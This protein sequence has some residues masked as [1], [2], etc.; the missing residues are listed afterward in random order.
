MKA[1]LFDFDGVVANTM[2]FHVEAWVLAFKDH[3]MMLDESLVYINEGSPAHEFV[4]TALVS[5]YREKDDLLGAAL[6]ASKD[7]YLSRMDLTN[8]IYPTFPAVL[9]AAKAI[10]LKTAIV[11]GSSR[12]NLKGM[13][14]S[15]LAKEF[16]GIVTADDTP[17]GKPSPDPY[18]TAAK[19]LD[20]SP[21]EC[22]VIEN[23]PFG[24]QSAKSA[25]MRC[26][27][28]CTTL[29]R[30]HLTQADMIVVNHSELLDSFSDLVLHNR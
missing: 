30:H 22:C 27:A 9:A 29:D 8:R 2:R 5:C 17:R 14:P 10:S 19:L 13:L 11:T 15:E 20:V 18:L 23:G 4:Y 28:L 12:E 1:I 6:V 24:I 25:G 21:S 16:D 7:E 26:V 3:G